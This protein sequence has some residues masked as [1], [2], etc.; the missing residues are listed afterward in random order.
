MTIETHLLDGAPDLYGRSMRLA[1]VKWMREERKFDG[2]EPLKAQM[3]IDIADAGAL[4]DQM[5]L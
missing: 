3:A 1:F 2:L 5:Q 4:F